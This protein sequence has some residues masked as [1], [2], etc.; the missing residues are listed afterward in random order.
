MSN[1]ELASSFETWRRLAELGALVVVLGIMGEIAA[2]LMES[3]DRNFFREWWDFRLNPKLF[4]PTWGWLLRWA[5]PRKL[6]IEFLS[7]VLVVGGLVVEIG[8]GHESYIISDKLNSVLNKEAA[9]AWTNAAGA[10]V[11]ARQLESTNIFLKMKL[12]P[13]AITEKQIKDF[14]F[15]TENLP[16]IPVR[17]SV[18]ANIVES[19]SYAWQIRDMFSRAQFPI[20]DSDTNFFVGVKFMPNAITLPIYPTAGKTWLNGQFLYNGTNDPNVFYIVSVEK[21][22]GFVRFNVVRNE[23]NNIEGA[24][25]NYFTQIGIPLEI[26]QEP[27]WVASNCF[28][29]YIN[30]KNQ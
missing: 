8:A 12:Q 22:N 1:S 24:L 26:K 19:G 20:P 9:D 30:P 5:K 10:M 17:V 15:L 7:V 14:I 6:R 2:I 27:A 23:T 29:I 3:H 25:I 18:A 21:T 13:R 11:L 28:E 16:K 4:D